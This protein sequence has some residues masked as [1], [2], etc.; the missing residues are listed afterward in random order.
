MKAKT[1]LL[2]SFYTVDQSEPDIAVSAGF[3]FV[4]RLISM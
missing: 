4:L 2:A 3:V 1:F